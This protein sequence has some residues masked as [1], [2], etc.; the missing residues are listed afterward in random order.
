MPAGQRPARSGAGHAEHQF[1]QPDRRAERHAD[2]AGYGSA[3]PI[4][5][6]IGAYPGHGT[7]GVGNPPSTSGTSVNNYVAPA[8]INARQTITITATSKQDAYPIRFRADSAQPDRPSRSHPRPPALNG[9]GS[10]AFSATGGSGNYVWSISPQTGSIDASGVYTAPAQITSR[11]RGNG[12]RHR[13]QRRGLQHLRHGQVTLTAPA[14]VSVTISP[15]TASLLPGQTPAIHRH[16]QQCDRGCGRPGASVRDHGHH[17][18]DR[19]LHRAA[20]ITVSTKV[21]VTATASADPT[22]IGVGRRS[23]SARSI[24]VGS[25]APTRCSSSPHSSATASARWSRCRRWQ[26]VKRLGTGYTQEFNG[27]DGGDQTR[28]GHA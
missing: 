14:T 26:T 4:A 7:V 11:Q 16:S 2:R 12:D 1:Q 9:G 18:P 24:D 5:P 28:A 13:D 23:R 21:T 19:T 25:G 17:R 8:A 10:T 3:S 6:S 27:V 22:K 15:N 20:D